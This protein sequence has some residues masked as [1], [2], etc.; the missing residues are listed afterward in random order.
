MVIAFGEFNVL[1]LID[2]HDLLKAV[3]LSVKQ[4]LC[5]MYNYFHIVKDN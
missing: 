1:A 5:E 2:L 4:S 3:Y